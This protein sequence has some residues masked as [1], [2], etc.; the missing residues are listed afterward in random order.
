MHVRPKRRE[1]C[2]ICNTRQRT[3]IDKHH[4]IPRTDPRCTDDLGNIA[5][6]CS[7]CHRRVHAHEIIIEGVF[8][9]TDGCR[10]FW[11]YS[12]ENYT[13]RPGVMLKA[14]GTADVVEG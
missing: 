13:I 5:I 11:H 6:I 3:V 8:A 4:I 10:L 14:D 1:F 9:T 7:N 2:E 12:G